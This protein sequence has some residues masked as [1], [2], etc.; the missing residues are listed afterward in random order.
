[1]GLGRFFRRTHWDGERLQEIESYI[2]IEADEN[3]ARGL[4]Y[5]DALA[6]ARRKFGNST[7]VR[8]DIYTMNTIAFLETL[9]R[10]VR[11][12]LRMLRHNPMFT[13]VALLTL[14]IGIG[15]NTAVFSVVNSVLLKPLNY[16]KPDELVALRQ[17]APG[18]A[19]LASVADGLLLSPSMYF[20]YAEHNRSFRSIGIWSADTANVT[21]LAEPEQVRIIGVTDGVLQTLGVQPAVGRW[22]SQADQLPDGPKSVMLSYG[23]WRRRFGGQRSAIGRIV[24]VDSVPWQIVGVMPNSFRIVDTDADLI[25]PLA[26]DRSKLNLAHFGFNGIARLKPGISIAQANADVTRMLAIWMDSWTNGPGTNPHFYETWRITPAIRPLKQEVVGNVGNVLW[27]VTATIGLVMLIAC[28]NV[29]NLFLVRAEARQQEL[30]VRAALGAGWGRIVRELLTESVLLGLLGGALAVGLAYGSLRLLVAI[31]PANLPR[32]AEVSLD[33]WSLG[34]TLLLSLASSLMCGLS[35]AFKYAGPRISGTLR[36][37]GRTSSMSRERHR[38]RNA[39]V[40]GQVAIALVLL[41]CA[42]LMIRTFQALRTV[43]PGFT[44]ARHIQTMRISIPDTLIADPQRVTRTQEEI[45]DKLAAVPGV[46][47]VGFGIEM[48]MEGFGSNWD[49]M[50]AENKGASGDDAPLRFFKFVSPGFFSAAGTRLLAGHDF[51]WEDL[52]GPRPV[53]I[54]SENLAREWWGTPIAAIG[55]RIRQFSDTP[56]REVIGVVQDVRENGVDEKPPTIVYWPALIGGYY[57]HK[58]DPTRA[59]TFVLRSQRAGA[60]SFVR[61]MQQAVWSVEPDLPVASIR[62]MQVIYDQSLSRT[63]FALVILGI[64]GAMA[65]VLGLIGIYGVISY[66]VSQRRREIGIRLALGAPQRELKTMFVRSGLILTGVGTG[67][68]LIAAVGLTRLMKS[69]LFG[70]SPLDPLTYAAVPVVLAAAAVLAS[71]IPARRA[72]AVDAVEALKAE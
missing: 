39:L 56:W 10:D 35:P 2:Q 1:M 67:I 7:L 66:A 6:A 24:R 42:G 68:G 63:S 16:S 44:D 38:T 57:G 64:T 18:A 34:F 22:L 72:A 32:L 49:T 59:V 41:V 61:H 43:E 28:A 27:V 36:S 53:L 51:T 17:L 12:G 3:I 55:K 48:P 62:T 46:T 31:G 15:A 8:E 70:I 60:Q 65:L 11:Y 13:A 52:Y 45:T 29:T 26:F 40:V 71:Y 54:V 25:I 23:Y 33:A 9:A 50:H 58:L 5:N 20:T 21:G 19:G 30:A 37:S 47:S 14:A 4:S 69:L